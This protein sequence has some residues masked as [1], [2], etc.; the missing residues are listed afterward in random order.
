MAE[1]STP[2]ALEVLRPEVDPQEIAL[3]YIHHEFIKLFPGQPKNFYDRLAEGASKLP[4][5]IG[6]S[7]L[8]E[9]LAGLAEGYKCKWVYRFLTDSG[10][11]WRLE[12]IALDDIRMTGMSPFMDPILAKANW[13]PSTFAEVWRSN[14][15]Y[16]T[17]QDAVGMRPEP[18]RDSLP[19]MLIERNHYLQV[20]DGMRRTCM[21]ALANK[22]D[23]T[24]WVGRRIQPGKSRINA[25]KTLFLFATYAESNTHD[26]TSLHALIGISKLVIREHANG[27]EVVERALRFLEAKPAMGEAAKQIRAAIQ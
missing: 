7:S 1:H 6:T 12:R 19:I 8:W 3:Q 4:Q 22:P 13:H 16:A 21:A 24:A 11:Q 17:Q 18:L 5:T 20:F 26:E 14:P 25:D 27:R 9:L 23:M 15:G 2:E 10:L